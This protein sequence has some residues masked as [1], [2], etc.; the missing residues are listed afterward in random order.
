MRGID[1][2]VSARM[3][4]PYVKKSWKSGNLP[5]SFWWTFPPRAPSDR[6]KEQAP[7]A[8]ELGRCWA[9]SADATGQGWLLMF[10]DRIEL[11]LPPRDGRRHSLRLIREMLAFERKE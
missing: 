3:G 11:Y 10:S 9:F 2:N 6:R 5:S 1:W 8:A 4:A 7:D